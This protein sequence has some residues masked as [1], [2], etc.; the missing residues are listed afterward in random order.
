[1]PDKQFGT[2]VEYLAKLYFI[3]RGDDVYLPE[4]DN[5]WIDFIVRRPDGTFLEIQARG[6]RKAPPPRQFHYFY[7]EKEIF[8][9][10]ERRWL[11]LALYS[12][13]TR[14]HGDYFL[15]PATAWLQQASKLFKD[16]LY[17]KPGQKSQPEWGLNLHERHVHLLEPYRVP[18]SL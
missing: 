13:T 7:I 14:N 2:Y 12:D 16:R 8:P 1:L 10:S 9:L 4:I 6:R 3:R 17:N 18:L 15:I 11:F 5:K